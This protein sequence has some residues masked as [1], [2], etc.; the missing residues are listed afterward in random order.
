MGTIISHS[1]A[2]THAAG[3]A[4]AAGMRRGNVLALVGGLGAGKTHFVKGLV[5]GLGGDA[6]G[7]TSPTF[8]LVHEYRG[9]LPVFHFDFYRLESEAEVF[10]IGFD[11]YLGMDGVCVVEWGDRY[12]A[13]MPTGARWVRFKILEG[14]GREIDVGGVGT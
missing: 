1:P 5:E 8:T 4:M 6:E 9:T 13:V 14:D 10:E 3:V 2:E 12:P 7:V 11:D